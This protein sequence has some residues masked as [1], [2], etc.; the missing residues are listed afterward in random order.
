MKWMSVLVSLLLM[1]QGA[2]AL[3]AKDLIAEAE[4][5]FNQLPDSAPEKKAVT[6]RLADLLFDAAIEVDSDS[7]AGAAEARKADSYRERSERLYKQ[8]LPTLN[9]DQTQRVR[10]QLARLYSFK[11]QMPEA[12]AL[13]R[14]IF[15]SPGQARLKRE[16]ALHWAEQLELANDNSSI[17]KAAELYSKALPLADKDSLRSY[18]LYRSAWSHCRLGESAK[19]VSLI[20]KSLALAVDKERD[21]LIRD[22]VLFLSRDAESAKSQL[23]RIEGIQGTYRRVGY[24]QAL[25]DAYLAADRKADYAYIL[26]YLNEKDPDLE[27]AVSLLDAAHDGLTQ[28]EVLAELDEI[29]RLRVNGI[30]FK[31]ATIEKK[32]KDKLFRLVH[33]WDG[34]RRAKKL[35]A[36][37]LLVKG[38]STMILLFP[39]TE[40]T[41]QAIGGWLAAYKDPKVQRPQV[42]QWIELA[43]EV[44][45]TPLE[46][47]LTQNKLELAR[48]EKEWSTVVE[49]SKKL[50]ML[51]AA[52]ARPVRYQKAKA[53]Y[54]L[55]NYDEA[56]PVFLS[57]AQ[58]KSDGKDEFKKLSQ[59]LALDI[60]AIQKRY[61]DIAIYTARWKAEGGVRGEELAAIGE[62]SRFESAVAAQDAGALQTFTQ[63]CLEK[64]FTPKSC[65]NARSLASRLR[66]QGTLITVLKAQGD[67]AELARQL[68]VAG[69]FGESARI[70]EKGLK[71]EERMPWLKVAL[72][73]ELQG[74][75]KERDRVLK[76]FTSHLA[77][78]KM[79]E[80]EQSLIFATLN[81]AGLIDESS[82]KLPWSEALRARIASDLYEVKPTSAAETLLTKYCGPAGAGWQ[83][84]HL[85]KM[86]ETNEKQARI[87]FTGAKSKRHFEERVALLKSLGNQA[88]CFKQ[89]APSELA[90]ATSIKVSEAYAEFAKAIH[91][92]PMPEG[93]DEETQAEITAQIAAMAS[94]FEKQSEQWLEVAAAITEAGELAADWNFTLPTETESHKNQVVAFDWG[95]YLNEIQKEPFVRSH[96][97][98]L[99]AHFE[100]QGRARLAAYVNG[101]LQD[102]EVAK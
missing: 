21:D 89:G 67:E 46:V 9:P 94:P 101:R 23:A 33:L 90:K 66:N 86:R 91:A 41:S 69:R 59:D 99:K 38:I 19:A 25:A 27:R 26:R 62:K 30:R 12:I 56:L 95:G 44:K 47:R 64:K 14:K 87:Q 6:L 78:Q 36:D 57:L 29:N 55:K 1:A 13:W 24:V 51:T 39:A 60:L 58:E 97:E 16:S 63:F 43:Q 92:T 82:L 52:S 65:D 85:K 7:K 83:K 71:S 8:V 68:E 5:V 2:S 31:N 10:F 37:A 42:D 40:E 34:N 88:N 98:Q 48:Q 100:N 81:E 102:M 28:K 53:L 77:K 96:F 20:E 3:M 45:H 35:G 15:E 18:I 49:V 93:L 84:I 76:K 50:E 4:E 73:F 75:L 54:E 70:L 80:E 17:R 72:L 11:A 79:T 74:E 61:D 22:M 32:S